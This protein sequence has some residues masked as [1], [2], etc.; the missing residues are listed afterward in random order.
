MSVQNLTCHKQGCTNARHL[1]NQVTKFCMM[2]RNIL[3]K[4]IADSFLRKVHHLTYTKQKSPDDKSFTDHFR[5]V[6]QYIMC[7]MLSFWHL[8]FGV[9]PRFL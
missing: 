4:I 1:S 9:A 6:S 5:Y 3:S 2:A 8:E 7:S